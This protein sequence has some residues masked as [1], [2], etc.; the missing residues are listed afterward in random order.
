[1]GSMDHEA[2]GHFMPALFGPYS[3]SREASGT[4]WAPDLSP[5]GGHHF[6]SGSWTG[7]VHGFATLIGD[8]QS[9]PRGD[10]ELFGTNMLMAMASRRALGGRLGVRSMLSLEPVTVGK[11]GY[12]LLLQ[13]GETAD[14]R[15]HLIDRQH[16]HDLFME[17]AV[18][19]SVSRGARSAFVYAG[20]PGEPALG[21]PVFMHRASGDEIPDAPITHHWLDSSHITFGVLTVGAVSGAWKLE[22]SLFNGREP[23]Q[24]RYDIE[25]P[26]LD[27][28]S[29]RLSWNPTPRWALQASHGRIT[30]PEQLEPEVDQ[31]RTTASVILDHSGAWGHAQ[32]TLAWGRNRNRPG[33]TLDAFLLESTFRLEGRHVLFARGE[34]AE[35]DELVDEGDPLEG[36]AFDVGRASAGYLYDFVRTPRVALGAGVQA[37]LVLVSGELAP[38]YGA[39][40]TAGLLFL[41]ARL[42]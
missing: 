27:S 30:S 15:T 7:M 21:P 38:R 31:D 6:Q 22:G 28:R 37:S 9:G 2:M 8:R 19:Y 26:E 5:H 29:L 20:L 32:T 10:D 13:S 39:V 3:V 18:T 16:P 41:R 24:H 36:E 14:G 25:N 23:D 12:P 42:R 1:M 33:R 11:E 35:K 17:L 40:P 4:A 34:M